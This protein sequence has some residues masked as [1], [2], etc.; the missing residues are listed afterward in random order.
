MSG[1]RGPWTSLALLLTVLASCAGEETI[2]TTSAGGATTAGPTTGPGGATCDPE[3]CDGVDN[4][5]DGQVDEDCT[6]SNGD[7]QPCYSGEPD[8]EGV[9][10]CV[11]GTQTCDLTGTWGECAGEVVPG[12]RE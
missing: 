3:Q 1:H 10:E 12:D 8:T 7:T 11:G 9:G 2:E 6:C 4:D 5:C